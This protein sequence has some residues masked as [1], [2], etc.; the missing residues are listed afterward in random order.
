MP[1][2]FTVNSDNSYRE[3]CKW[4]RD[5]YQQ[6]KY[7]TFSEPRIGPERS[8]DQNSL[9]HVWLTQYAAYL[10]KKHKRDV[11][12]GELEGMKRTAKKEFYL[13]TRNT[14]MIHEVSSPKTGEKKKDY[15]S[16]KSWKRMEM[17]EFLTWIQ[18]M[19]AHDGLVLES[20]GEFNKINRESNEKDT[21]NI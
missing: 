8:I 10:L 13:E 9:L 17:F 6:H 7:I 2:Y 18:A 21:N 16:S 3:F 19:A 1:E 4:V 15:T 14:W 20:K 5:K 11:T 12:N